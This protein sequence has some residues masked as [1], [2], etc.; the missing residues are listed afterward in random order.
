MCNRLHI[1]EVDIVILVVTKLYEIFICIT[2]WLRLII[3]T[4]FK[5]INCINHIKT[6]HNE[7]SLERVRRETL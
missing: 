5:E 3:Y 7:S 1:E 6:D 4:I 2:L